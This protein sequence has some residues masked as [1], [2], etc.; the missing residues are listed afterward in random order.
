MN[1]K[2]KLYGLVGR[3]ISHSFSPDYFRKKFKSENIYASYRLIDLDNIDNLLAI[4][5]EHPELDGFNVTIPY[6]ENIINFLDLLDEDAA[7]IGAVNV[8]KI[9]RTH[10]KVFLKGFNTDIT[11]FKNSLLPLINNKKNIQALI[12][13][14][15]GASKAV[16]FVLK[17]LSIPYKYVSRNENINTLRYSNLTGTIIEEHKLIINATPVGMFPNIY[18]FPLIPY[19]FLSKE[20]IVYDLVY[21]PTE[22]LFIKKGK[23]AGAITKNGLEMLYLQ[24]EAAWKIWNKNDL[25]SL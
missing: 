25:L 14:T 13:G 2:K 8:V 22:T 5:D 20:H 21:N 18:S 24:A 23:Q 19:N 9:Y 17:Q 15:G 16:S 7:E 6:K 4:I 12:L 1:N 10:H 11:G 3:N